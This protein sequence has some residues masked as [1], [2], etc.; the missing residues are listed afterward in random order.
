MDNAP[1]I[2][3]HRSNKGLKLIKGVPPCEDLR[4]ITEGKT[5]EQRVESVCCSL[6]G[7][8]I[9]WIDTMRIKC[10]HVDTNVIVF[11]EPSTVRCNCLMISPKST[12]LVTY[13]TMSSGENLQFWDIKERKLIASKSCKRASS[14]RPTFSCNEDICLQQI[15]NEVLIFT[16][17][18]L[19]KPAHRLNM[20]KVADFG[21]SSA[22][23]AS[24]TYQNLYE[25]RSK[26][27]NHHIAVYSVGV[28]GQPSFVRLYK[29]PRWTE[30]I[31][32]KS[33]FNADSVKFYWS[34][35]GN[36]L[37]LLCMSDVDRSGKNYYGEQSLHYLNVKGESYLVQLNKDGPIANL[38]WL[39]SCDE[40]M[41]VAV[42]GSQPAVTALFNKK[43]EIIFTM[44]EPSPYNETN[45][46][47]HGNLI[48]LC[49]FGNLSGQLSIWDFM[50]QKM[51]FSLKVPETTGFEWCPDGEHFITMTTSPRLRVGN[52]F[53]LWHYM[54]SLLHEQCVLQDS[55]ERFELYDVKWCPR[56]GRYKK[57]EC[58][59]T[60]SPHKSI[61]SESTLHKYQKSTAKYV[62]PS[63]R[64]G[65]TVT[66]PELPDFGIG[67]GT[68]GRKVVGLDSLN[69]SR[70]TARS[71]AFKQSKPTPKTAKPAAASSPPKNNATESEP[72]VVD[73]AK[74][75]RTIKRKLDEIAKLKK[76]KEAGEFIHDN[77][78]TKIDS[79]ASLRLQLSQLSNNKTKNQQDAMSTEYWLI[80]APGEK[81]CQQT[82]NKLNETTSKYPD[83][84]KNFKFHIPDLKVG[85]L[86]T[87]VGL[88]DDLAK[89]DQ[90]VE[91]VCHKLASAIADT[92]ENRKDA[93]LK[94]HILANNMDLPNYLTRFQWDMAK[95]PIKQ[96]LKAL[97]DIISKQVGQIDADLKAKSTAYNSLRGNLQ[98][99]ERKQTGSLLARNLA[100]LVKKEHFVLDSE[101]L[102]TL[103]V[104]V[105]KAYYKDWSLNFEKLTDM[106]VPKSSNLIYEDED[107]GLFTVTLFHKVVD[108]FKSKAR[109]R[110]FV[111][112]DFKYNESD[113]TA[114][115]NELA[116]LENDKK[117]QFQVLLRWLK[118]NFSEAFVAWVHVKTL[119]LFVES[120]LRYGLPVN[121]LAVLIHPGRKQARKL[122]D[123]LNQLYSHLD[124]S[125]SQGPMDDIPGLNLGQQ[126]YYPY[127]YFKINIDVLG[128][129]TQ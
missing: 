122:R 28:K 17:S 68:G 67:I 47:P 26:S 97:H 25:R 106:V 81:T 127:V 27:K 109:E 118:V 24:S 16:G 58:K 112:R 128:A 108:E 43:C 55:G 98:T 78:L 1:P 92:L 91:S 124:T 72:E 35:S 23:L 111:V 51:I 21:L 49:G 4:V 104:V 73:A 32:N 19:D 46:S 115:K 37:L 34:P 102:T 15:N 84:C 89:L 11:D 60:P 7:Q 13:G 2:L 63:L 117:K 48:A 93:Q 126:E 123:V 121:F 45:I 79:E 5:R 70:Q 116:K 14:W 8:L 103:L 3:I 12:R 39:P 57:P 6:D 50:N 76:K 75:I 30:C 64:A 69:K 105:P 56:P 18:K 88:S 20:L 80:S 66:A 86:D 41:F 90:F 59:M 36:S 62:P 53:R 100:D 44:G 40:D 65:A 61:L 33:F 42:Y 107:H 99:L 83:L 94:E 95:Y 110:K 77:Q 101:Y 96:S 9:A 38:E 129:T 120:I 22:P 114:G 113:I 82:W 29:Y 119:R 52:G 125:I 74:R 54:G 87:L 31:T 10:M 71:Q 85:T